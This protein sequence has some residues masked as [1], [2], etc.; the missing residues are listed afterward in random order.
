MKEYS[1]ELAEAV[2]QFL[3]D[4]DWG[5]T[6]DEERGLF[7]FALRMKSKIQTIRYTVAVKDDELLVYG[8]CP[9]GADSDD[10]KMMKQMSEFICRA[11]WGLRNG[12]FEFDFRDGE[13]RYKSFID[14]EGIIPS[15]EIIKN[16][17]Y[18]MATM[19][20]R[21]A[22]GITAIIFTETSAKDAFD[23]CERVPREK[24]LRMLL[25]RDADGSDSEVDELIASL[26]DLATDLSF[27][28]D[29]AVDE[30]IDRLEERFGSTE[31]DEDDE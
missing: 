9:I 28:D 23:M 31:E 10:E 3:V 4:D 5:Y 19:Y 18:V 13:I 22:A 8:I 11:N 26:A 21:Y 24:F 20:K 30:L 17:V 1:R 6:F 12:G 15:T 7:K 14:C 2:K 27:E 16:S 25:G 29:S